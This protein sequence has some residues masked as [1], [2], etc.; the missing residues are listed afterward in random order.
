MRLLRREAEEGEGGWRRLGL[1]FALDGG[2]FHFLHIAQLITALVAENDHRK[3]GG[4][5]ETDGDRERATRKG[6]IAALQD[7][8]GG[9]AEHEHRGSDI[10]CGD[11]MN[12]LHL[13]DR[14]EEHLSEALHLHA[15]R[16]RRKHRADRVLHPAVGD[17]NP[18]RG[19]IRAERGEEGHR[20]VLALGQLLPTEE[21]QT[22]E[23]R[24]EKESH[25][26]F[27]RQRRAK[28]VADVLRVIRPVGAELEL[29]RES[30]GD[31]EGE[32]NPEQLAPETGHVL[33]DLFAGH[34][35]DRLHDDQQPGEA[36]RQRHK[37]KVVERR[38]RKLP[39]R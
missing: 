19:Q 3:T 32:V 5:A 31:A 18:Q 35:I 36:K 8:P 4:E 11:R 21:K 33:V 28:H 2:E 39:S 16:L 12:E 30:G 1:P 20:Q 14:V 25:E 26:A 9:N 22:D 10:A 6:Q 27:N 29:H 13:R 34:D 17:E 24:L 7:V 37:E 38:C 15:H 23:G